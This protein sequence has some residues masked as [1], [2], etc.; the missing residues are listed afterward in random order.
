MKVMVPAYFEFPPT[1]PTRLDRHEQRSHDA[2]RRKALR[3]RQ[4]REPWRPRH[5]PERIL[6]QRHQRPA[7]G[8]GK[9]LGYVD[10]RNG[11]RAINLVKADI[12]NWYGWY[13]IDGIFFDQ[14][15]ATTGL[16]AVL[17][18]PVQLREEQERH[19]LGRWQPWNGEHRLLPLLQ[20]GPGGGCDVHLRK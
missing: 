17:R 16:R 2:G 10:T 15:A 3:H 4:S 11:T 20:R 1:Y 5:Q 12:D 18:G 7:C 13:S 6:R 9:V 19:S 8:R 14:M